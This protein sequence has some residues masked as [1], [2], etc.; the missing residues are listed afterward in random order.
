MTVTESTVEQ[1]IAAG[2]DL[3]SG[4]RHVRGAEG[5]ANWPDTVEARPDTFMGEALLGPWA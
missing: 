5:L 4:S 1:A 3:H 2:I